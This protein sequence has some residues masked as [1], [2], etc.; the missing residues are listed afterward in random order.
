MSKTIEEKAKKNGEQA[1]FHEN[2]GLT[3]REWFAGMAMQGMMASNGI[4]FTSV[5]RIS[6]MSYKLADEMLKEGAK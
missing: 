4:D 2:F 3:K 5:D 1:A 6:D